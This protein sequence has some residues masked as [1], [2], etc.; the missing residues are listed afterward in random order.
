MD[1]TDVSED[2]ARGFSPL[3]GELE[4]SMQCRSRKTLA[5]NLLSFSGH[6][7]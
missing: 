7:L 2:F 3:K 1:G 5:S 6:N 4:V